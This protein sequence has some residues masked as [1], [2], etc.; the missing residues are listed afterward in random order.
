MVDRRVEGLPLEQVLGWAE[1]CGQ[2][3]EIDPGVFVP[4]R[5]TE[6]L[7]RE[8]GALARPGAVA[9]D[10]C[11]GSGA[12]GGALASQV[13]GVELHAADV[14]RVAARCAR[15]N[16]PAAAV[17]YEGDLFEALP[18]TLRGRIDVLVA[19]VPY[20][21]TGEI[22]LM[23]REA[24]LH[25]P[26]AALDGGGDGLDVLRRVSSEAPG[27]LAPGGHVLVE[28]SERQA[29]PAGQAFAADG[30]IP[31]SV[32]SPDLGATVVVGTKPSG[33]LAAMTV[34]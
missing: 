9:V 11:C 33:S 10:L 17:V 21:P 19:N 23:P 30:L 12:V 14:D 8:A 27:W 16:L 24:R 25:E 32:R 18:E 4:R 7:A 13:E 22:D 15:R 28:V 34:A 1:L 31:R 5:R 3:I 29:V 6:L 26:R 2:R 20:V